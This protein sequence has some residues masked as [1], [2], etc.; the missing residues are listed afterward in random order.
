MQE[1][2]LGGPFARGA[3]APDPLAEARRLLRQAARVPYSAARPHVWARAFRRNAVAAGAALARHVRRTQ[4]SDAPLPQLDREEPRLHVRIA[5]TVAAHEALMG[6]TRALVREAEALQRP[7]VWEMVT[8][9][10][11]AMLLAEQ[12]ERHKSREMEIVYEG[13]NQDLGGG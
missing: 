13:H 10:E 12:L 3:I 8:L 5:R 2:T 9:N 11:K 6:E 4:A 1:S 7:G